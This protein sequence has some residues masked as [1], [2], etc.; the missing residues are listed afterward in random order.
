MKTLFAFLLFAV[1]LATSCDDQS[2]TK[3]ESVEDYIQ[4]LKTN[5]YQSDILPSFTYQEIPF[6]L[7]YRNDSHVISTFPRNTISSYYQPECTLGM[8]ALWT[9]ESIRLVAIN[10]DSVRQRFPSQN[11]VLALRNSNELVL[12]S[13]SASHALA[14]DAYF[15]W[16]TNNQNKDFAIVKYID[17]LGNT[18]YFWH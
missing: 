4:Q 9:I 15:D 11:P 8:Y 16:W 1:V 3:S 18:D 7:A 17:P 12:V 2:I 14:A 6:L 10:A 13:D 5:Q